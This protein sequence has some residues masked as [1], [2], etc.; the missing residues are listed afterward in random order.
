MDSGRQLG[1]HLAR[2]NIV[3]QIEFGSEHGV[4]EITA[5]DQWVGKT[6]ADLSIRGKYGVSVLAV[7]TQSVDFT[8]GM[9][10]EMNVSPLATTT[11]AAEDTLLVLGHVDDVEK[12]VK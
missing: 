8:G 5:P 1:L 11:I 2:P 3:E 12:I 7:K 9:K 6:L 10:E 4:F